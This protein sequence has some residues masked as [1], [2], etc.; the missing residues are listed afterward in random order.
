MRF[1]LLYWKLWDF[2]GSVL[3]DGEV[4]VLTQEQHYFESCTL[5]FLQ[6]WRAKWKAKEK[7]I[8][9][10][11]SSNNTEV[12]FSKGQEKTVMLSLQGIW[13]WLHRSMSGSEVTMASDTDASLHSWPLGCGPQVWAAWAVLACAPGYYSVQPAAVSALLA[14]A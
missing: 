6:S 12:E 13:H 4:T 8:L 2:S 1:Q 11:L 14:A 10:A 7:C 5:A 9:C 3:A